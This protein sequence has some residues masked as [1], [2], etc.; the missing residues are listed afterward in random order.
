MAA[1]EVT[2]IRSLVGQCL[3]WSLILA[4]TA[5]VAVAVVVPRLGGAEP[6]VIET[7]SMRPGM[8]PGTLVV[9][10]PVDTARLTVGSVIT[11]QLRSGEPTVV[12]H[13]IVGQ[14]VDTTGSLRFRTQGDA[15]NTA[16]A[17]WVRPVQV[18]GERWYAVPLLGYVTTLLTGAQRQVILTGVVTLLLGY[19]AVMF[20]ADLRDRRRHRQRVAS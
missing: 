10:R 20:A 8:P 11:Y 15:N 17:A 7:G 4:I 19:A 13:R 14:G 9:V 3:A 6:Y 16:D 18:K 5:V 2:R 12:T 1:A